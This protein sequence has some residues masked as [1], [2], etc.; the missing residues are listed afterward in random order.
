M[1]RFAMSKNN[2]EFTKL[3]IFVMMF[4]I[5]ILLDQLQLINLEEAIRI[6]CFAAAEKGRDIIIYNGR[7]IVKSGK[8]KGPNIIISNGSDQGKFGYGKKYMNYGG[9]WR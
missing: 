7:V 4:S 9:Y 6:N 8:K 3:K 5:V 2:K 1:A